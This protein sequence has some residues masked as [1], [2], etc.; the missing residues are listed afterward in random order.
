MILKV[1]GKLP[2]KEKKMQDTLKKTI[3]TS[4]KVLLVLVVLFL[5]FLSF[6]YILPFILAYFFASL[7]EPIVKFIEKKL[8]IPRK[9]GSVFS[10]FVVLGSVLSLL[11]F[12]V[13]RLV[14]EIENVYLNLEINM[15]G[16]TT[17][18]NSLVEKINGIYIRL[19][20]E[21]T[22]IFRKAVQNLAN[23]LQNLLEKV[24]NIAQVSIQFALNL[25]QVIIF[26]FVTILATY[27]MSSDKNAI[28]KFL[29]KQI[30]SNWVRRTRGI[31]NNVFSAMFGWLRAQLIIM[32]I[33]FTELTIG[34]LIIGIE[35]SLLL[36]LIIAVIDILPVLGAGTVLVPW[37]IINLILGNT[38]LGLS[39][40]LLYVIILFVRQ[41]IEPK[42]VGQQIGVHPLLTLF[43]MYIGLKAF[44]VAGMILGPLTVVL[45]KH[46][47]MGLIKT[48][49]LKTW[50]E[51][52]ICRNSKVVAAT[53]APNEGKDKN[54]VGSQ[55]IAVKQ[56]V[57]KG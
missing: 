5:F 10:I 6:K 24:V 40:F 38:K 45:L 41:L 14:K 25:P 50:I 19:P 49:S 56:K 43:G 17:F 27:F 15:D 7:I 33:T 26:I 34:L 20:Q 9:I 35:N 57:E 31:S 23:E 22:D 47:I 46:V 36:A 21:V 29:E 48:D 53:D 28:L 13:Y 12:V 51:T 42:I 2:G 37:A 18:F 16:V 55:N 32:T 44:G 11:G 52:N 39:L 1:K 3:F 30:P 4:L 54:P 8:H